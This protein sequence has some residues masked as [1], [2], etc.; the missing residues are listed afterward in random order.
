[1]SWPMPELIA[2]S[3]SANSVPRWSIIG[4]DCA[5]STSSGSGVGP[6]IRRFCVMRQHDTGAISGGMRPGG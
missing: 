6:G 2:R 5:S 3:I 1:M 4:L